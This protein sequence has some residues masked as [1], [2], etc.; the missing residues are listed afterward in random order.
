M[1]TVT[2]PSA[3]TSARLG[4]CRARRCRCP[5][6]GSMTPRSSAHDVVGRSGGRRRGHGRDSTGRARVISGAVTRWTC[7]RSRSGPPRLDIL[8]ASATTPATRSTSSWPGRPARWPPPTSPT[9]STCTP[10][11]CAPTSSACARSACSR[12]RPTPR[13]RRPAAA[14]LLAGPRRARRSA[15][16]RRRSRCWPAC[17][18]ALAEPAGARRRRR[19]RRRPRAGRGRRRRPPAERAAACVDALDRRA[20]RLGFDPAV[21]DDDDGVTVAFTHCPFRRAGRGQPRPG[22]RPAPGLV[23]GFVDAIGGAE[24]V[25]FRTLVDRDPC[26]VEL[27]RRDRV[28]PSPAAR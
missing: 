23:E 3:P 10:T 28:M 15:S 14:P 13:R 24:V 26:Q 12:S 25:A 8:K 1:V 20:G 22:V 5:S 2:A 6:S 21:A 7:R 17:C 18:C 11:P 16:S 9:R 19:R 4:P 27:V